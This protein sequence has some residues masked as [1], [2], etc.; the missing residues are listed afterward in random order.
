MDYYTLKLSKGEKIR[1]TQDIRAF[2]SDR[3][4][5]KKDSIGIYQGGSAYEGKILFDGKKRNIKVYYN[6]LVRAE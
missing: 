2:N 6:Y 5:V 1:V 3:I 4:L